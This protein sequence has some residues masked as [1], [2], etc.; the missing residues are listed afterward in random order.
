MKNKDIEDSNSVFNDYEESIIFDKDHPNIKPAAKN[1]LE[2]SCSS[3]YGHHKNG[4]LEIL[5]S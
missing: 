4:K 3:S 5:N 2:F 1:N